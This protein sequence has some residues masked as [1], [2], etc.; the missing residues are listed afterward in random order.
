VIEGVFQKKAGMKQL[1]FLLVINAVCIQSL[2]GVLPKFSG[3]RMITRDAN[4]MK[5][6][7]LQAAR[8]GDLDTVKK[9]IAARVDI[10]AKDTGE[11]TALMSAAAY[12]RTDIVKFLIESGA[13]LNLQNWIG[14]TALIMASANGQS[15]VVQLLIAQHAALMQRNRLG[16][17]A[18]IEAAIFGQI[19]TVALLIEAMKT[20]R[21][22][23]ADIDISH[24]GIDDIRR[25][26]LNELIDPLDI[27]DYSDVNAIMYAV[28]YGHTE[29]V[30]LLKNAGADQE[31][32]DGDGHTLYSLAKSSHSSNKYSV[33]AVLEGRALHVAKR[34]RITHVST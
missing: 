9:C 26:M 14:N 27:S 34:R 11:N 22:T 32:S 4:L 6:R 21:E 23:R 20:E 16:G 15:E 18:L 1:I 2:C 12:G 30:R 29:I 10:N 7:L 31:I 17:T 24:I 33:I 28:K 3:D 5:I 8:D 19:T 13:N 25:I